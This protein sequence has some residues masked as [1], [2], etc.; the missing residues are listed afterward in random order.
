MIWITL[1]LSLGQSPVLEFP[2]QFT[3]QPSQ[4]IEIKPSQTNGKKVVY[5]AVSPGLFVFPNGLL[6]DEKVTVVWA[7][8]PGR[9]RIIAATAL[10]DMPSEF[11]Q[12]EVVIGTPPNPLPVPPT[13]PVPNPVDDPVLEILR[14][15][16]GA[17]N[18][19]NK[20]AKRDKLAKAY[21][22]MAEVYRDQ[23]FLTIGQAVLRSIE[24]RRAVLGDSDLEQLRASVGD[25]VNK[26]LPRD[27][28][29]VLSQELRDKASATYL[30]M[31]HLIASLGK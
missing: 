3:G 7:P 22:D 21:A 20:E 1:L 14:P 31:S 18:E 29:T 19:P 5:A 4:P 10:A 30:R 26:I 12:I 25:E 28:S 8:M 13:P 27:P 16:W 23:A 2:K 11:S 9:Y 24:I 15:I 17:L 6:K